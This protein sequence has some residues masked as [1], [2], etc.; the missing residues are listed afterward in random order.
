MDQDP[1]YVSMRSVAA[2]LEQILPLLSVDAIR[3]MI[4]ERAVLFSDASQ[5]PELRM[6][7]LAL[8]DT[9]EYVHLCV[10]LSK[11][12]SVNPHQSVVAS[13]LIKPWKK[14]VQEGAE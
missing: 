11:P 3:T 13:E 12:M 1:D 10:S 14:G 9:P 2:V 5:T 4:G 6:E 8:E 7:I